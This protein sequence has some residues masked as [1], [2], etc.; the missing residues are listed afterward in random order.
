LSDKAKT[1]TFRSNYLFNDKIVSIENSD[2]ILLVGTNP[3]YEA[4]VLNAR[5]RK[6]F[7]Y[8]ENIEIGVIGS[9]LDFTYD[10][11]Y[12]GNSAS[13]I[14]DLLAGNSPFAK[15]FFEAVYYILDVFRNWLL[16]S[17]HLSS[18]ART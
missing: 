13:A 17:T 1:F 11:D 8:S 15:V 5:I 6:A 3:R 4:P 10:F 7:L 12:L 9:K 2:A 14:N 16:L 18:L